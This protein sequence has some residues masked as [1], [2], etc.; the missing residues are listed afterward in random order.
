MIKST[1]ESIVKLPLQIPSESSVRSKR[2]AETRKISVTTP[3]YKKETADPV[4]DAAKESPHV[5]TTAYSK[6]YIK[7]PRYDF[8]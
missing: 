5:E 6:G 1:I 4:N 8:F 7:Y 3:G 2:E